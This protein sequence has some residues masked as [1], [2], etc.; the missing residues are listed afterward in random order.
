METQNHMQKPASW[1]SRFSSEH[2]ITSLQA[3]RWE[4]RVAT[5]MRYLS[6]NVWSLNRFLPACITHLQPFLQ[7]LRRRLLSMLPCRQQLVVDLAGLL[8]MKLKADTM[9][10][11]YMS[12]L[13][14]LLKPKR[15]L[16]SSS[17]RTEPLMRCLNVGQACHEYLHCPIRVVL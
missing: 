5:S 10:L 14:L 11:A 4:K 12:S 6:S 9:T 8:L 1:N 3:S 13:L 17:T 16:I 2:K 7:Q 15:S